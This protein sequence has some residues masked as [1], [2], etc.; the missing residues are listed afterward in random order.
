M[1]ILHGCYS[2]SKDFTGLQWGILDSE[3]SMVIS[4]GILSGFLGFYKY[5]M[6]ILNGFY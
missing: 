3:D 2:D 6:G 5:S 1:G 4:K